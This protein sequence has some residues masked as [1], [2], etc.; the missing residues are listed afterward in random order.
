MSAFLGLFCL[1]I[2][3]NLGLFCPDTLSTIHCE[4]NLAVMPKNRNWKLKKTALERKG[5]SITR[6][7]KMDTEKIQKNYEINISYKNT[8]MFK[9]H[10]KIIQIVIFGFV[11]RGGIMRN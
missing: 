2:I 1:G 10:R 4:D 9:V 3:C 7:A 5:C 6:M 11:N 8:S